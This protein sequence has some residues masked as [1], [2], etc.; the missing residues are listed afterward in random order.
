MKRQIVILLLV[1][2]LVCVGLSGCQQTSIRNNNKQNIPNNKSELDRFLGSWVCD[3]GLYNYTINF[4]SDYKYQ[5]FNHVWGRGS[6]DVKNGK[7]ILSMDNSNIVYT[8]DYYFSN[9]DQVFTL[10][11]TNG[12]TLVFTKR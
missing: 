1:T 6:Y 2:L 5:S 7:L 10:S 3:K 9:N 4:F 12:D 8:I 11:Y